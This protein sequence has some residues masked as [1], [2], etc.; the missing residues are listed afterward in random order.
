MEN[1]IFVQSIVM[2]QRH[3]Y[4][5][6]DP[7]YKMHYSQGKFFKVC[8]AIFHYTWKIENILKMWNCEFVNGK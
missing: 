5:F 7:L 3:T 8:L 2:A 4:Q 1:F 6:L